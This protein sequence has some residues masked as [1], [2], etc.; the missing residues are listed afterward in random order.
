MIY[1]DPD[2]INDYRCQVLEKAVGGAITQLLHEWF[3]P[4]Q[5]AQVAR[6][7][8]GDDPA[9]FLSGMRTSLNQ[10]MSEFEDY[11]SSL[12]GRLNSMRTSL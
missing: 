12:R 2:C 8:L 10:T 4:P 1:V 7:V 11:A 9:Q 6:N 5:G 3:T